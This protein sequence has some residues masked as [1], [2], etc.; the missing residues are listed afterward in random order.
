MMCDLYICSSTP[1]YL[2][3]SADIQVTHLHRCHHLD[4]ITSS[5]SSANL[6]HLTVGAKLS[7]EDWNPRVQG[8]RCPRPPHQAKHRINHLRFWCPKLRQIQKLSELHRASACSGFGHT[9][10][11]P[12]AGSARAE[13]FFFDSH[14]RPNNGYGMVIGLVRCMDN[15]GNDQHSLG[16]LFDWTS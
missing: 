1:F 7:L 3:A 9:D 5:G 8:L 10:G 4:I 14:K 12:Q 13:V 2:A 15:D 6:R 11:I 16:T